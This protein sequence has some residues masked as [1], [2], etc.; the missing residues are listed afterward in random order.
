MRV[1]TAIGFAAESGT[2][3][4]IATPLTKA[5]TNPVLDAALKIW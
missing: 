1:L 4:Y 5:V 3:S 2:Q